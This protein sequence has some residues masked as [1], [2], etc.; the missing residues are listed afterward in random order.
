MKYKFSASI[1]LLSAFVQS[2]TSLSQITFERMYG[3]PSGDEGQSVQ[4]T[5]DGGFIIAGRTASFGAGNWDVYLVRTDPSGI[6]LWTRTFGGNADDEGFSVQE[7]SDGGFIIAGT[8]RSFGAGFE[9]VYLIKTNASGDTLWTKTYGGTSWDQGFTVQETSDGGFIIAG[10]TRSF[11]AGQ[12]DVYLIKCDSQGDTLWTKTFGDNAWD[13]ALSVRETSDGGFIIAGTTRSFGAGQRDVYLIK[14][15][16][17]GNSLWARTFGGTSD[18]EGLCVRE[19]SDGGFI[20]TGMTRSFGA[21]QRDVY[22]IKTDSLGD[23]LW[24][25][26]FGGSNS[27]EGLSVQQTL[28]SGY[29]ITGWTESFGAGLS[30]VYM[31]KTNSLGDTLWTRTFG[32]IADDEGL[33]VQETSEGGFII[34]GWTESFGSGEKDVYLI[35]TDGSGMVG[36]E[37]ENSDFR[38]PKSEIR[39]YHNYPNP[40]LNSTTIRYT[41]PGIRG[42]GSVIS[43]QGKISIS[44]AIY[45]ISGKL[46]E[47]LVG[48]KQEPRVYQVQWE[49]KDQA[50]GIYFYR[51]RAGDFTATRKMILLK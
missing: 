4:Q 35:K 51:L 18:D 44:L 43:G 17:S 50:S 25:K 16:S 23:T 5:S 39:L 22:L 46:V 24:T 9:D 13:E 27:D 14:T 38:T 29:F 6:L 30:D 40:F 15:D 41:L 36:I 28:D 19:T 21:G 26:T 1:L 20:I 31:I 10:R 49:G 7:T 45:D 47:T 32:G 37:E 42:Q 34:A 2:T 8:T 3:G 33:S 12:R 11:G 48:E